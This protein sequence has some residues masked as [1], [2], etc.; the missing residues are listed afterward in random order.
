MNADANKNPILAL[1]LVEKSIG[2]LMS[3]IDVC[4]GSDVLTRFTH[5]DI[6]KIKQ[7]LFNQKVLLLRIIAPDQNDKEHNLQQYPA[8]EQL[9]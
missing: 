1:S 9:V 8:F 4:G 5:I 3:L 2:Q 6:E 7:T